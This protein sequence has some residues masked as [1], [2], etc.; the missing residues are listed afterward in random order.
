M[1]TSDTVSRCFYYHIFSNLSYQ[2]PNLNKLGL[3]SNGPTS[4]S[5]DKHVMMCISTAEM[6]FGHI[7]ALTL[8][9]K[10]SIG[11]DF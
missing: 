4:A 1:L 5:P 2:P 7:L 9:V 10:L 3:F 11:N 8:K 6:Y